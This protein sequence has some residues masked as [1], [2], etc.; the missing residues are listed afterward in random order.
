MSEAIHP[1][2][3][4]GTHRRPRRGSQLGHKSEIALLLIATAGG[5]RVHLRDV[6]AQERHYV[7]SKA[8]VLEQMALIV[9]HDA[10]VD[11][12]VPDNRPTY[13]L[14]D[15]GRTTVDLIRSAAGG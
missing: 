3:H 5:Q 15:L 13:S 8:G 11:T 10:D 12:P 6:P 4:P 2:G 7:N 1:D 9:C 14:T